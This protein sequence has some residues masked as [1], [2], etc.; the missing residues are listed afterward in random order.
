M[1][2]LENLQ[3]LAPGILGVADEKSL[4]LGFENS[5]PDFVVSLGHRRSQQVAEG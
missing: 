3:I 1:R 2:I 5:L 4:A